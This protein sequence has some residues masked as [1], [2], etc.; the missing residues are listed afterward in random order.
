ALH[1]F[2]AGPALVI[3][4]GG[5]PAEA[6]V[7]NQAAIE[8]QKPD[9]AFETVM[10][11]VRHEN[12]VILHV[13]ARNLEDVLEGRRIGLGEFIQ[14][15]RP[16]AGPCGGPSTA[17]VRLA[18][19]QSGTILAALHGEQ[20]RSVDD[21]ATRGPRAG[22][23]EWGQLVEWQLHVGNCPEVIDPRHGVEGCLALGI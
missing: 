17:E 16:L 7:E 12:R 14:E 2:N 1:D 23:E 10:E 19:S 9:H 11:P 4:Y 18:F 3:L 20:E 15:P 21:A 6:V 8:R 5:D 22:I 13:E